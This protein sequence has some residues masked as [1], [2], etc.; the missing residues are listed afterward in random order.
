MNRIDQLEIHQRANET[1]LLRLSLNGKSPKTIKKFIKK[2]KHNKKQ[3]KKI[4]KS[5]T[6]IQGKLSEFH[7]GLN[8][9]N[10]MMECI[11]VEFHDHRQALYILLEAHGVPCDDIKGWEQNDYKE[12][13]GSQGKNRKRK[14]RKR[15]TR[16]RRKKSNNIRGKNNE[17]KNND[18]NKRP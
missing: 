1:E 5:I 14:R 9:A 7:S 16:K 12:S 10:S 11:L 17:K 6:M 13:T 18:G 2:F 8:L 3:I 15:K 4:N